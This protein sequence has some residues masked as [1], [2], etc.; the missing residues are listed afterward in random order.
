MKAPRSKIIAPAMSRQD[1]DELPEGVKHF[2]PWDRMKRPEFV[3]RVAPPDKA[4]QAD[5]VK[6][7]T[8]RQP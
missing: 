5:A 6:Y 3:K 2:L 4:R 7:F 1:W 8:Q